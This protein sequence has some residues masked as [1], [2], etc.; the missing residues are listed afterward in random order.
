M[1]Q[2]LEYYTAP[3]LW[4]VDY[5]TAL[6]GSG[7]FGGGS[8]GI[9]LPTLLPEDWTRLLL[10]RILQAQLVQGDGVLPQLW[11]WR[12]LG[13][14]GLTWREQKNQDMAAGTW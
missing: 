13:N 10:L 9:V 11:S 5:E 12:Q 2:L 8:W 4:P 7:A 6:D 3:C 14:A 1:N